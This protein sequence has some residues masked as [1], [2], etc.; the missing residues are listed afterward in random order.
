MGEESTGAAEKSISINDPKEGA[1]MLGYLWISFQVVFPILFFMAVGWLIQKTGLLKAQDFSQLNRLVF[2]VFL[3]IKL[4]S[5]VYLSDF[6]TAFQ[7]DVVLYGMVGVL[8]CFL[9]TW[10]LVSRRVKRKADLT[11]LTQAIFRS[12]YVLFGMSIAASLYPD[13]N[14]GIVSVLA[15]FVVPLFNVLAVI[16]FECYREGG[17]V[18]PL[19]IVKG[20]LTNNLILGSALGLLLLGLKIQLPDLVMEP[21]MDLGEIAT[22][23]ALI[24]VGATLSFEA[25]DRYRREICVAA[26]GRL[27]ICPLIFVGGAL[28]MGFRGIALAGLFLVFASPTATSSY[29]MAKELGG[30]GELA[31]LIVAVNNV[32][33]LVTI[34]LWLALLMS[35]NLL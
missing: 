1:R 35:M 2:R 20:I 3:P 32:C 34:F 10:F 18:S 7:P 8:I 30:N 13:T 14:L 15:A 17:R 23:L 29:P 33:S 19:K 25:L 26:L 22:P 12:N 24:C 9:A 6:E 28:M 31:G 21:L 27:V 11:V 4:F 5:E 16:L